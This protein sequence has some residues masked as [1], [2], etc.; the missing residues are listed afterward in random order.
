M[1]HHIELLRNI[2]TFDS[3]ASAATT[4]LKRL[5]LIYS[6][7]GRG[8]TTLAAILRS[9][10][11]GD[12]A[13]IVERR[14]LGSQHPPQ[15]VL[16]CEGD[17]SNVMFRN[18][19]WNRQVP[20][21]RIY[22]DVFVEQNVYSGL[23]V[24]PHHR[25]NLHELVLGDEGVAL[26]HRLEK[27][28]SCNE[29]HI[30]NL[31]EKSAAIPEQPRGGLSLDAFC[32]LPKLRDVEVEIEA[33]EG[34]LLAARNKGVVRTTSL[35]ESVVLPVFDTEAI[36]RILLMDLLGLDTEAE[37]RVQ[38]HMGTL[39]EGGESWVADGMGRSAQG[40]TGSCPFCGQNLTGS[41]L[42]A[43]YR[44]Y[45]SEGYACLKRDVVNMIES[46]GR[47]HA[48]GIQVEF[49]RSI[50]KIRELVQFWSQYYKMPAI[51]ID[52][53]TVVNDWNAARKAVSELLESKQATPL[54]QQVLNQEVQDILAV[55]DNHKQ[56]IE[57]IDKMLT[58]C[59]ADILEIKKQ[60]E[61]ADADAI[62]HE[63]SKLKATK[64]RH[65]QEISPLCA[66]YL[67]EKE[68]K[69][70]TDNKRAQAREALE[71]YRSS[72]FPT[73]Q[74]AVNAYL[75][76]FGAGFSIS[77]F[78]PT[79]I[80]GGSTCTYS[81]VIN[82]IPVVVGRSTNPPD[83]PSFRNTLSAGD[84]NTLALALFF[85][86]LD[87]NRDLANT[88]TVIDDPISSLDD[89][90]SLTTVQSVRSLVDRTGQVIVLSHNKRFL[91]DIWKGV[92]RQECTPLE[93]AMNDTESI[94][95]TWDI[96][97]DSMTEYDYRHFLLRGYASGSGSEREVAT[98][99]RLHLEGFLRV[100]CPG[101]FPPGK[102]LGQF[103]RE[104]DR[105]IGG[106]SEILNRAMTRELREIVEYAN[107]FHHD[108][109][110]AWETTLINSTE[111]R[112]FVLRTLDFVGPPS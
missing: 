71:D 21:I 91:Y 45:F 68:A 64:V 18:G 50:G 13:P 56:H 23:S 32:D 82:D 6:D 106:P 108:T 27:L 63:L 61:M 109:N 76:R 99:I 94:I 65:S 89:H 110:P 51:E 38:A 52:T 55:Y 73:L 33:A 31:K 3:D 46:I 1:I 19:A 97:Q 69:A 28:V 57:V 95:R 11:T 100:A 8:K 36:K 93:I 10:A 9:L 41:D 90:R 105:K 12:P 24:D 39:G 88:T 16:D 62:H 98:A 7:N 104:C 92:D 48:D 43:H 96:S 25:Q 4:D 78:V 30:K 5:V 75:S 101:D 79:N 54:E 85:S 26:N 72:V 44:A 107:R 37:A 14:R 49:E 59:N 84:R 112:G 87:Q 29:R 22:D 2:G 86:S 17:P 20:H 40:T 66:G 111:L 60:V 42:I 102:L 70:Q 77:S 81:V 47:T 74:T 80:R 83:L 58:L 15:V 35:F 103:I 34:M 53:K 67:Q